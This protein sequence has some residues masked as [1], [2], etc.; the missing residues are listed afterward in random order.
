MILATWGWGFWW[1]GLALH[2]FAPDLFPGLVPIYVLTCTLAS[3]GL[4]LAIF[5]VR[6]RPVWILLASVPILANLSLLLLPLVVGPEGLEAIRE[7]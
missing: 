1:I 2:R 5:T 7:S 4:F 3:V 6:A